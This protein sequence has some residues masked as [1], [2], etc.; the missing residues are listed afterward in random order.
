TALASSSFDVLLSHDGP[1]DAV[2]TDSGSEGLGLM[3][4]L[5]KPSFAFFGHYGSR[6]GQVA[7]PAGGTQVYQLAGF[8]LR[9]GGSCAEEGSVGLLSW[10]NG[11][12]TFHYLENSWLRG[13]TRHNWHHERHNRVRE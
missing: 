9:R 3:L 1:R 10:E 11:S 7:S 13:F 2:L 8:E 5:A 6:F 4:E 12:G